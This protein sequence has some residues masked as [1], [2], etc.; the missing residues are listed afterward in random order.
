MN[1]ARHVCMMAIAAITLGGA[2]VVATTLALAMVLATGL[3][4]LITGP[5]DRHPEGKRT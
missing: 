4:A 2:L 1:G 3:I 5:N